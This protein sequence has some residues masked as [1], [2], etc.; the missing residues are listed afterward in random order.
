MAERAQQH[1]PK[2]IRRSDV[3]AVVVTYFPGVEC[4]EN[5]AALARQVACLLIIDNGSSEETLQPV[6]EA[7]RRLSATLV[8]LKVNLGIAA[9]LNVGLRLA[10]ERGYSWLATFDQD[11]RATA[12]MIET[13]AQALGRYPQP[14]RVA[15]VAP[16]HVD[17]LIGFTVAER[18]S[19][20][21]G[22]GW[23]VIPSVMTSGNLVRLDAAVVVGGFDERLFIDFVDH[24]FCFRLRRR[25]FRVLE[26][27]D[28]MLL[29]SLG[30]MERRLL[31]IKRVTVTHH[32]AIRRYYISRN[33]LVLWRRYW[34]HEPVWVLRDV[35]RF[36][37]DA[38]SMLL[39]ERQPAQK[40]VMMS[41]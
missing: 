16:R 25:G 4:A 8:R 26:A 23:R 9:A 38:V 6:V 19:E 18:G 30:S 35:R 5:L 2:S 39:F 36:L 22:R 27:T 37:S 34:R 20:A 24:D 10:R 7:A 32:A 3:C 41:R 31:L 11:S 28:A 1:G 29:H 15:V 17:R 14:N 21:R 13:M 40:L 33:R 12:A